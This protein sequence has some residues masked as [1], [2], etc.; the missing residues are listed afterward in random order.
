MTGLSQMR[1]KG[2]DGFRIRISQ[3]RL[4]GPSWPA[5]FLG[6]GRLAAESGR[7]TFRTEGTA[8]QGAEENGAGTEESGAGT[9]SGI[10]MIGFRFRTSQKRLRG[11]GWPAYFLRNGR[12]AAES[13]GITFRA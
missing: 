10:G 4:R 5:Y 2:M 13:G 9:S 11:P 3:K 12:Q 7:I 8:G 1:A 6:N